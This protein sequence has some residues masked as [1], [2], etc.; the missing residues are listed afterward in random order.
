MELY[1]NPLS[2]FSHKTK[3]A[4]YEKDVGFTEILVDL[5]DTEERQRYRELY[6]LGKV[7]CL[8]TPQGLIPESTAIIEWLDQ[9]YQVPKLIPTNPDDARQVR[10]KDRLADL[11]VT[12]NAALLF[13]QSLKPAQQQDAE[14]IATARRQINVMYDYFEKELA[15]TAD[16]EL[17]L[18][19]NHLSLADI[20][21]LA[22]LLGAVKFEPLG[23]HTQ[24][25][26]YLSRHSER[27]ALL[28]ARKGLEQAVA[29]LMKK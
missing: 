12:S 18:H 3:M 21:L 8:Q 10:L 4:F 1:C 2:S 17:F 27:P 23:N 28:E 25:N 5:F 26:R 24:L 7:P 15:G 16:A 20:A 29:R 11:Y 6:P 19:G 9:H 13:F 22:G 14:R